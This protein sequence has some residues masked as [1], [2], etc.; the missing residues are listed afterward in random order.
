MTKNLL[1]AVGVP[2]LDPSLH[3]RQKRHPPSTGADNATKA[4]EATA[5]SEVAN[6]LL[7]GCLHFQE[8]KFARS[9]HR[10][11]YSGGD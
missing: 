8:G 9:S 7:G 10:N 4:A 11:Y 6:A 5:M 1:K 2:D 3:S